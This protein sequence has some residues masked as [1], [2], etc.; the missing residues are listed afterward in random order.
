MVRWQMYH[1]IWLIGYVI[2]YNANTDGT[3]VAM[4]ADFAEFRKALN[5]KS[6]SNEGNFP[7]IWFSNKPIVKIILLCYNVIWNTMFKLF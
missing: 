4:K 5:D 2:W 1:F 6:V 3:S 7:F